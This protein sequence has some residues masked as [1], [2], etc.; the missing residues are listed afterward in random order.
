[1]FTIFIMSVLFFASIL[2]AFIAYKIYVSVEGDEHKLD[3][4]SF[5]PLSI[6]SAV[7]MILLVLLVSIASIYSIDE[8]EGVL[9]TQF[10]Q[11]Y[12]TET[13][14]GLH[15]KRPWASKIAWPIRL[16]SLGQNVES[17]TSDDMIL[18]FDF[19]IMWAVDINGLENIYSKVAKDYDILQDGFLIPIIR[20][21]FRDVIGNKPFRDINTNRHLIS[22]EI[23]EYARK[24][25]SKKS[26]LLDSIQIRNI[27]VPESVNAAIEEKQK[28][29]QELQAMQYEVEKQKQAAL[30][31]IEEAKG[32]AKAQ[33]IINS[34]LTP[35]Y[36]QHE[37]I[38]MLKKLSD[39]PN[40]TFIMVPT[41]TKSS[42][43]PIIL[44]GQGPLK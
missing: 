14:P 20:S 43:V 28:K 21:A 12:S 39:S 4:S 25:L 24:E 34:T 11:I 18:G 38:Q 44:N 17:R 9:L 1:M 23:T 36:L 15:T 7:C 33:R 19:Q 6:I 8:G 42:G 2:L 13:E 30:A 32:L 31:R 37:G 26:I 10:G 27:I 5:Y 16:K 29:E 3:R 35:A 40:T 41:G 22:N